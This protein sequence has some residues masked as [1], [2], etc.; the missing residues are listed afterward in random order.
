MKREPKTVSEEG[1]VVSP[2]LQESKPVLPP[3]PALTLDETVPPPGDVQRTELA[4]PHPQ[5]Q[6]LSLIVQV[7]VAPSCRWGLVQ[8]AG[9]TLGREWQA[10]RRDDVRLNEFRRS[11]L[12]EVQE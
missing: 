2:A 10:F 11:P 8:S 7:R 3:A 5:P 1:A 4:K 6:P 12:L 9:V